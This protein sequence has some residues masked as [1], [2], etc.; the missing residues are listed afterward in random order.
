MGLL[1]KRSFHS[2][3]PQKV[4]TTRYDPL[5]KHLTTFKK[6]KGSLKEL[7]EYIQVNY[8]HTYSP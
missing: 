7:E 1:Y 6:L 5:K 8:V 3:T 4:L 2:L